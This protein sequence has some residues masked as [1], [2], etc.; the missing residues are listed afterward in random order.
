M[1]SIFYNMHTKTHGARAPGWLSQLSILPWAQVII[2]GSWDWA[3]CQAPSSGGSLLLLLPLPLPTAHPLSLSL[4]NNKSLKNKKQKSMLSILQSSLIL[5]ADS[6]EWGGRPEKIESGTGNSWHLPAPSPWP[7][8]AQ[9][10]L[11]TIRR[12]TWEGA[13]QTPRAW[14]GSELS[15]RVTVLSQVW[16]EKGHPFR[17]RAKQRCGKN[18]VSQGTQQQTALIICWG[19]VA[20]PDSLGVSRPVPLPGGYTQQPLHLV[21]GC[22]KGPCWAGVWPGCWAGRQHWA[23]LGQ[24][25]GLRAALGNEVSSAVAE[26]SGR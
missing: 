4:S 13:E 2:S 14:M 11:A 17:N 15:I 26:T 16:C 19:P 9:L 12:H 7:Q 18:T 1:L 20:C 23:C 3:H 24:A 8:D 6:A 5:H 21:L 22:R 10:I 25:L